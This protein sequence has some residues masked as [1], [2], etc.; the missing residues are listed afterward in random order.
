[1]G[2]LSEG[3]PLT[4]EET[5]KW[6]DHV[7]KHG[8][9]QFINQYH[10][11]KDRSRDCLMWGDEV[12]FISFQTQ[13]CQ[14]CSTNYC[15]FL[16]LTL[17]SHTRVCWDGYKSIFQRFDIVK[18]WYSDRID[19]LTSTCPPVSFSPSL[20]PATFS[21]FIIFLHRRPLL[22]SVTFFTPFTITAYL[23]DLFLLIYFLQLVWYRWWCKHLLNSVTDH[24][25]NEGKELE[26]RLQV[27][28]GKDCRAF[29]PVDYWT[30]RISSSHCQD[31]I[32]LKCRCFLFQAWAAGLVMIQK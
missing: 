13:N 23:V 4:W 5:K 31:Y 30:F 14:E 26:N 16:S 3:S 22:S 20:V 19:W 2:L 21:L 8:I 11:L 12:S 6:T 17:F 24:N 27:V 1:M 10:R 32:H 15:F 28:K 7:R 25:R 18:V 29:K 9:I